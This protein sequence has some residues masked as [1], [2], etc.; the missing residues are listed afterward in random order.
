MSSTP[1]NN[2]SENSSTMSENELKYQF[3][4]KTRALLDENKVIILRPNEE[5]LTWE[6]PLAKNLDRRQR[7]LNDFQLFRLHY[8]KT[9]FSNSKH[10]SIKASKLSKINSE[11]NEAWNDS[12]IIRKNYKK[13]AL[14]VKSSDDSFAKHL[15]NGISFH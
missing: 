11:I 3:P 15:F 9:L 14:D 4:R 6:I 7:N 5:F 1:R 13:L 10:Q 12:E 2:R 8:F